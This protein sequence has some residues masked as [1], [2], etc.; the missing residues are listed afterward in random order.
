MVVGI[1]L[2]SLLEM[3][4]VRTRGSWPHRSHSLL[5]MKTWPKP[6]SW[7][8]WFFA[9]PCQLSYTQLLLAPF[10]KVL[11]LCL[12]DARNALTV[13][14]WNSQQA[15]RQILLYTLLSWA[16]QIRTSVGLTRWME[17][18]RPPVIN[19]LWQSC[20]VGTIIPILWVKKLRSGEVKQ[21][22]SLVLLA[23]KTMTYFSSSW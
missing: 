6:R 2:S 19:S 3:K 1:Q 17:R 11:H 18:T 8:L 12:K 14:L 7:D 4:K 10:S 5:A 22:H 21:M 13:F 20:K 15:Y 16:S 9:T 23:I